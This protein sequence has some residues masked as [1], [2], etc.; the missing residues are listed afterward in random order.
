[1]RIVKKMSEPVLWLRGPLWT[2]GACVWRL[3]PRPPGH[4]QHDTHGP[5]CPN[6]FFFVI[7]SIVFESRKEKN[8]E[9]KIKKRS[10]IKIPAV[11]KI[12]SKEKVG[13]RGV[14]EW[15]VF[16]FQRLD[17]R[18]GAGA[19]GSVVGGCEPCPPRVVSGWCRDTKSMRRMFMLS[20]G[21]EIKR[22][23]GVPI[24]WRR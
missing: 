5:A 2:D 21:N 17:E 1:M 8:L 24:S 11:D 18:R 3:R 6:T 13:G 19:V 23:F 20:D 16:C 10:K 4:K 9:T 15:R 22:S 12:R 14:M 7:F